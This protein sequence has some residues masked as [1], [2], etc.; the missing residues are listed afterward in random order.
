WVQIPLASLPSAV[1]QLEMDL[2][3]H[4]HSGRWS[5]CHIEVMKEDSVPL[6]TPTHGHRGDGARVSCPLMPT[7]TLLS[8]EVLHNHY[9]IL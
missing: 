6:A 7:A 5:R 4:C 1:A 3:G 2:A 8:C 9:S